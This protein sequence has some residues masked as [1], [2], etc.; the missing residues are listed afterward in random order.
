M[1]PKNWIDFMGGPKLSRKRHISKFDKLKMLEHD[2]ALA[3][4]KMWK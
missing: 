2:S 4:E 1:A 3:Y